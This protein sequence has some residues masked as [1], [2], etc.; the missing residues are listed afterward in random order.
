MYCRIKQDNTLGLC[1]PQTLFQGFNQKHIQ[2]THCLLDNG[3]G[4]AKILMYFWV[5][6]LIPAALYSTLSRS[7]VSNP[8][9]GVLPPCKVQGHVQAQTRAQRFA[10]VSGLKDMFPGNGIQR[11]WDKFSLVWWLRH[12]C[13]PNQE[14][15]AY[16]PRGIKETACTMGSSEVV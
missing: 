13:Q 14:Q 11:V 4:N 6:R 2:K 16:K 1:S 8:V 3:T 9:S 5:L 7:W 12:K 10:T 15:H